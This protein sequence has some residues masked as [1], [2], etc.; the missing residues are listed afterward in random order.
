MQSDCQGRGTK[1]TGVEF[2]LHDFTA[3][4]FLKLRAGAGRQGGGVK[5]IL[6]SGLGSCMVTL[7]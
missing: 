2:S 7:K 6:F 5:G 1:S 3:H 4:S